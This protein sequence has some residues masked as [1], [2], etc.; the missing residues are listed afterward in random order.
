MARV[1]TAI[2]ENP[3]T[4][5]GGVVLLL[6]VVFAG[7]WIASNRDKPPPPRKVMQFTVVNVQPTPPP[8]ALPPPPPV[9]PPKI[10][11]QQSTR[12]DLK[13]AQLLP[14]E[15][16]S[17]AKP[18]AGPLALA[19]EGQGPGDAFNLV[20]NPGGRSLTGGG[21]LGDGDGDGTGGG[22]GGGTRFGWYYGKVAAE[23]EGAFRK[24]PVLRTAA[25]RVELRIWADSSGRISRVQ[26]IR[27]TGDARVD[28]A[29]QSIVGLHLSEAPPSDIPM[30]MI[31]RLT[32]RRPE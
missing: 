27:S 21:G 19:T 25:A 9:Q 26:L 3:V 15:P 32:A 1:M 22:G 10:E 31:A 12:V 4:L 8:K 24:H 16:Q 18:A 13:P 2:R 20:G 17:Q 23:V 5:A 11:E 7:R 14:P 30:P 6:V 29:I 28:E